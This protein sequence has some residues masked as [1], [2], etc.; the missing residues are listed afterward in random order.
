MHS[1][2]TKQDD[3]LIN[4]LITIASSSLP[5]SK[6]PVS[7]NQKITVTTTLFDVLINHPYQYKQSEVFYEVHITRLKKD[8]NSLKMESYKLQRSELCSLWGWGIHG[9]S[10]G[11]LALIPVESKKYVELVT[12]GS[13]KK[14]NAQVKKNKTTI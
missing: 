5:Y 4:S 9:D 12:N 8:P 1:A 3:D 14:K 10:K 2:K 11:R 7:K 6:K 13:V